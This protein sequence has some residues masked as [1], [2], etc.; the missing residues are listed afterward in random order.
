MTATVA[1]AAARKAC[2]VTLAAF[3][4]G[5]Q[6]LPVTINGVPMHAAVKEFSTGSFGWHLG[7]KVQVLVDGKLVTVQVG[8]NLTVVGSKDA[9]RA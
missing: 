1:T 7:G 8:V 3:V 9:D 6:P 5:A 2:P 4:A